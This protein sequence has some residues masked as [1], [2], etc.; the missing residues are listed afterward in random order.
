MSW[1]TEAAAGDEPDRDVAGER[2]PGDEALS[3]FDAEELNIDWSTWLPGVDYTATIRR[4]K[5]GEAALRT[6]LKRIRHRGFHVFRPMVI[7][8]LPDHK[9]GIVSFDQCQAWRV[10]QLNGAVQCNDLDAIGAGLKDAAV[11]LFLLRELLFGQDPIVNPDARSKP[12]RDA[13][14]LPNLRLR[15]HKNPAIACLRVPEAEFRFVR[16]KIL[17]GSCPFLEG[18]FDIV[19][20]ETCDPALADQ[21]GRVRAKF[22]APVIGNEVHDAVGICRPEDLRDGIQYVLKL[23]GSAAPSLFAR[24]SHDQAD[25][26]MPDV[27]PPHF[28]PVKL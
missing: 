28:Y 24:L 2:G 1:G 4:A 21:L 19:R 23:L 12:S 3:L 16:L 26:R 11:K 17:C 10:D 15:C 8:I 14:V 22:G 13:T 25:P 7:P 9:L 18:R 5:A 20:M 6:M 27:T